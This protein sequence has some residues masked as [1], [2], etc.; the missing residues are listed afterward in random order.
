[1]Q[2][3]SKQTVDL[4][5]KVRFESHHDIYYIKKSVAHFIRMRKGTIYLNNIGLNP[6][7]ISEYL[8]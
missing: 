2:N 1:M 3:D 7:P 4:T 6:N 8:L 5:I